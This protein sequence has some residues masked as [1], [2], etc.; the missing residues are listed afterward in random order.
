MAC[1]PG[2]EDCEHGEVQVIPELAK[3]T[4]W[5]AA[6]GALLL[7]AGAVVVEFAFLWAFLGRRK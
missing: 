4:D 7:A 6:A 3:L 5:L 2:V 1:V